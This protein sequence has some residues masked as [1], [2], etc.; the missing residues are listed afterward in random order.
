MKKYF[1]IIYEDAYL[2]V[3]QKE[4][5]VPVIPGRT[6]DMEISLKYR[7]KEIYGEIFVVHRIDA[8]T[9]GLVV[10]AKDAETHRKLNTMFQNRQIIK[11]YLLLTRG[12]PKPES[13]EIS[14]SLKR[15]NN[16]NKS[17]VA[18]DGKTALTTYQVIEKYG[19]I[20]LCEAEIHSGRHHQLRVHF[21][22]INAPLLVDP[23]Y[24]EVGF[25][26]SEIK[27]KK[28]KKGRDE[29]ERPLLSRLSLHAAKLEFKHP[30]QNKIIKL[31]AP[32]P[33]DLRAAIN[34][35]RKSL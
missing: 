17:V 3:V 11:K 31:E 2:I 28:Y 22:A 10:M 4:A 34:Q 14:F 19:N 9:S 1:E 6:S 5:G 23:T 35:L 27:A 18:Q 7:L 21:K 26:L 25:F 12:I 16:Q 32:L 13:G 30:F 33:K 15:L 8:E 29:V 20:A 24:A